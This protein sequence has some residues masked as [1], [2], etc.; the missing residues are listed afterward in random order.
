ME[1]LKSVINAVGHSQMLQTITFRIDS[2]QAKSWCRPLATFHGQEIIYA[3]D[4]EYHTRIGRAPR[5]VQVQDEALMGNINQR[6][7]FTPSP[8]EALRIT[9]SVAEDIEATMYDFFL[10]ICGEEYVTVRYF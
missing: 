8:R 3:G 10:S 5:P 9:A 2:D 1:Q 6:R 4:S 7:I